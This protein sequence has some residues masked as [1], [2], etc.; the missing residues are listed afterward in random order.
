MNN[1]TIGLLTELDF[2]RDSILLGLTVLK[3]VTTERYDYIIKK[4]N[5]Y[6]IQ[7]KTAYKQKEKANKYHVAVASLTK[8]NKR[9]K[10]SKKEIDY[11]ATK[12]NN[13]WILIDIRNVKGKC[14]ISLSPNT[15]RF[16][17]FLRLKDLT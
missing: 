7:V 17:S 12:I 15:K 3:P 13:E 10:Y 1:S 14:A 5:W 11:I 8:N 6:K 9:L 4:D 16:K 2:E